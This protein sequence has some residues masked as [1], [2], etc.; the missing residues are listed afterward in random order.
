MAEKKAGK[1]LLLVAVVSFVADLGLG[2]YFMIDSIRRGGMMWELGVAMSVGV[3]GLG[4]LGFVAIKQS[5]KG[6]DVVAWVLVAP[7]AIAAYWLISGW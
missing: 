3:I 5:A 7:G 6:R 1:L 2:L 4:M